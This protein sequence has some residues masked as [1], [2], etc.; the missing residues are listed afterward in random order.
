MSAIPFETSPRRSSSA[1]SPL[2]AVLQALHTFILRRQR[3]HEL[4]QLQRELDQLDD[5]DLRDIG[6]ER[7]D[8]GALVDRGINRIS[9]S[10]YR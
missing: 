4:K 5:R 2:Q 9:L 3:A 7:Q 6:I 8:I 1:Y 10:S